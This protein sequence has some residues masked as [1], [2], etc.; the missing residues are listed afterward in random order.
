[1]SRLKKLLH[2]AAPSNCDT[3]QVPRRT[4]PDGLR[5]SLKGL[6]HVSGA[7]TCNAQQP[8]LRACKPVAQ[9]LH[10]AQQEGLREAREERAA[11][12]EFC[13]GYSRAEAERVAGILQ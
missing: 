1:M 13:A 7:S 12:L 9:R 10:I 5:P 4:V 11:I 2:V 3:Q 6:L 8:P